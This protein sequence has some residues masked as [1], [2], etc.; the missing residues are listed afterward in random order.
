[1]KRHR[2]H[3]GYLG[4]RRLQARHQLE[5]ALRQMCRRQRMQ[6]GKAGKR[7]H[8]VVEHRIILHRARAERIELERLPEVELR[9]A[10]KMT[11]H[12]LLA[13]FGKT[14]Y[15]VAAKP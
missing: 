15:V 11:H 13:E 5:R 14:A 3:P 8:L 9:E 2:V 6:S 12:L 7:R 4:E 10:Q 1:M